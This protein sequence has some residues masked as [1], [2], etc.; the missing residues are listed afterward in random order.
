MVRV[1]GKRAREYVA[2]RY[3]QRLCDRLYRMAV[4][5][6][7]RGDE[8]WSAFRA[9]LD[10]WARSART[11]RLRTACTARL[12][13]RTAAGR[14]VYMRPE[15]S[16]Y[17]RAHGS[18]LRALPASRAGIRKA[19][20]AV[21]QAPPFHTPAMN[22]VAVPPATTG[23]FAVK[24]AA[25]APPLIPKAEVVVPPLAGPPL[26][27]PPLAGPP[28]V[29]PVPALVAGPTKRY[30]DEL[31]RCLAASDAWIIE[32]IKRS[33][34]LAALLP[35]PIRKLSFDERVFFCKIMANPD[36]AIPPVPATIGGRAIVPTRVPTRVPTTT[37]FRFVH[38]GN[39]FNAPTLFISKLQA[40]FAKQQAAEAAQAA[41]APQGR[42]VSVQRIEAAQA[43][44]AKRVETGKMADGGLILFRVVGPKGDTVVP[45]IIHDEPDPL[46]YPVVSQFPLDPIQLMWVHQNVGHADLGVEEYGQPDSMGLMSRAAEV[47]AIAMR[48]TRVPENLLLASRLRA[49]MLSITYIFEADAPDESTY[50]WDKL[51][52]VGQGMPGGGTVMRK[53]LFRYDEYVYLIALVVAAP[54][55]ISTIGRLLYGIELQK[56][57]SERGIPPFKVP[58][59]VKVKVGWKKRRIYSTRRFFHQP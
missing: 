4:A 23:S 52:R 7:R 21:P 12:R 50:Q 9:K 44:Q 54:W 45:E 47:R 36:W 3:N 40:A 53:T 1:T 18:R 57:F 48:I 37:T 35:D 42:V 24:P 31:S 2:Q 28:L 10:K 5:A 46:I 55:T 11:L 32:H 22:P 17:R 51:P 38:G 33:P 29:A 58:A 56:P 13:K 30:P 26:V 14:P 49:F 27:A 19:Q 16:A 39:P 15:A 41:Q 25:V 59:K 43:P 8:N 6:N 34:A 20:F